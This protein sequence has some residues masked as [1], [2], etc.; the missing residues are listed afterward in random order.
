MWEHCYP[1]FPKTLIDGTR[2]YGLLMRRRLNGGWVYRRPTQEEEAEWA[3][4]DAW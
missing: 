4:R 3:S 2:A 1:F